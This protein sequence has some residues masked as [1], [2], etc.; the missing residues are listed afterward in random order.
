MFG[1]SRNSI[2]SNQVK[3]NLLSLEQRDV[4]AAITVQHVQ[5][6]D[7]TANRSDVFQ[8][9]ITLD[10]AVPTTT[11]NLGTGAEYDPITLHQRGGGQAY[12][13]EYVTMNVSLDSTRKVIT[14][15]G[16]SGELADTNSSLV[17]GYY[18]LLINAAQVYSGADS[19][20]G[21][22]DTAGSGA[23]Y[24][25]IGNKGTQASK[26]NFFRLYGDTDGDG[27]VAQP[28]FISFRNA[29]GLSGPSTWD[30]DGNGV[31]DTADFVYFRNIYG[32]Q[33]L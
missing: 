16:F 31:V 2:K 6:G 20:N 11:T 30:H 10:T 18:D 7:G 4:P 29:F 19:I 1:K 23:D 25:A 32:W 5:F 22:Y 21:Q 13:T 9:K 33:V 26:N 28:D 17:N 15:S 3:P 24:Y 12:N 8:V 14:L 27:V